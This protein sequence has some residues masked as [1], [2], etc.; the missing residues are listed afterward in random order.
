VTRVPGLTR[1]LAI[2]L[3]LSLVADLAAGGV[4]AR[5]ATQGSPAIVALGETATIGPWSWRVAAV[6]TG[7]D[8]LAAVTGAAASNPEPLEGEAYTVVE[9]T[10]TNVSD[11]AH[12]LEP[13]DFLLLGDGWAG[14]RGEVTFPEPAIGGNVEPGA[15]LTGYVALAGPA[16]SAATVL[17]YDSASLPGNWADAALGLVAGAT[18]P[19]AGAGE[20]GQAGQAGT[21]VDEAVGSG[22]AVATADW[23]VTVEEVVVGDPVFELYP[24]SDYRTTAL[25]R[26]QAGDLGDADG[27][28]AAGWVAVRVSVTY[29]GGRTAGA[30]LSSESFQLAQL[31]GG[32]LPDGL[33]LTAPEPAAEGWYLPGQTRE[34]WVVF[35]IQIS[36]DSDAMRFQPSLIDGEPR[37]LLI[38]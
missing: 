10:V 30:F 27:D 24:A 29:T 8:A 23:S 36:W 11:T 6:Q 9:L 38:Y 33:F 18:L 37:Y 13:S 7:P 12:A 17:L 14:R 26:S 1:L 28:G 15:G 34:G 2:A 4:S 3:A 35:E 25:G 21:T 20:A 32:P 5:P 31:D 16:D 22:E 19:A